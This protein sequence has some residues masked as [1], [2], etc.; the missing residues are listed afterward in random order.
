MKADLK[1]LYEN[2]RK[3][4]SKKDIIKYGTYFA[5]Y[6]TIYINQR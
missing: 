1:I 5:K 2:E 6:L 3:Q 4:L